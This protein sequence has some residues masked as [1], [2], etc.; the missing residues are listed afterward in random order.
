MIVVNEESLISGNTVL[1]PKY[2]PSRNTEKEEEARNRK[3]KHKHRNKRLKNK[4]KIIRSIAF[5]FVLGLIL[6]GRYSIIYNMQKELN[7]I[8][9]NVN[10]TTRRG[11]DPAVSS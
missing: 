8:K 11:I 6:V 9:L 10:N 4:I 2:S 3:V 1:K 5:T 7:S